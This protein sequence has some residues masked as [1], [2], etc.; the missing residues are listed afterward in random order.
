MGRLENGMVISDR[1]FIEYHKFIGSKFE[2]ELLDDESKYDKKVVKSMLRYFKNNW[3]TNYLQYVR[4]NVVM[5]SSLK[6][7]LLHSK[8][9]KKSLEELAAESAYKIILND[10]GKTTFPYVDIFSD[11]ESIKNC[12]T[13]TF[14][15]GRDRSKARE[16]I[17]RL[18]SKA[19]DIFIYDKYIKN[20]SPVILNLLK[21]ILPIRSINIHYVPS[22]FDTMI[23]DLESF[24]D[25]W[26]FVDESI[27]KSHSHHDRYLVI[28]NKIEVIL[29][30]GFD[31]LA[32]DID[33]FTYVVREIKQNDL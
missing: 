27:M 32:R 12:L 18:C 15:N 9:R 19:S 21:F 4:N 2:G 3:Y 10:E 6:N 22:H 14:K 17:K 5:P 31:H 23:N 11:D 16:H 7:Q 1:L 8:S 26:T 29:T 28:D 33:D 25:K 30:S 20:Q 13:A 24:C